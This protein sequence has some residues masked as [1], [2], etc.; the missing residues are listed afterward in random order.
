MGHGIG[1]QILAII[2][3]SAANCPWWDPRVGSTDRRPSSH[4]HRGRR[5]PVVSSRMLAV[6]LER[7]VRVD[8]I[9]VVIGIAWWVSE[10]QRAISSAD[11]AVASVTECQTEESRND[12]SIHSAARLQPPKRD[13]D[14]DGIVLWWPEKVDPL[15]GLITEAILKG[16]IRRMIPEILSMVWSS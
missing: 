1:D 5:G 4:F 6:Q 13:G 15:V 2:K 14:G 7:G 16:E 11:G 8:V 9:V 3:A 10:I 12:R